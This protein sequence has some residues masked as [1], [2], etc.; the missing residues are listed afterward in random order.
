MTSVL[1]CSSVIIFPYYYSAYSYFLLTFTLI[2][3]VFILILVYVLVILL[4]A[5]YAIVFYIY[6]CI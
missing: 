2:F 1:D 5:Y 6:N 3:S 4:N